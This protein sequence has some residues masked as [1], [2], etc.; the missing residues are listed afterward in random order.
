SLFDNITA[1]NQKGFF[2]IHYYSDYKKNKSGMQLANPYPRAFSFRIL[3]NLNN[4][5]VICQFWNYQLFFPFIT[6]IEVPEAEIES[7]CA[8][9]LILSIVS[10]NNELINKLCYN[11]TILKIFGDKYLE[12]GYNYL[13]PHEGFLMDFLNIKKAVLLK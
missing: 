1:K 3:H 13:D 12:R 7:Y 8:H 4:L 5:V 10:N 11:K 6:V 2:K 9:S